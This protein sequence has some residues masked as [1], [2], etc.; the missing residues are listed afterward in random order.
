MSSRNKR[1]QAAEDM[2]PGMPDI[3]GKRPPKATENSWASRTLDEAIERSYELLDQAIVRFSTGDATSSRKKWINNPD[4]F[5]K[6]GAPRKIQISTPINYGPSELAGIFGLYSGG[7]DSVNTMHL[8]R[9][10]MKDRPLFRHF[11][12]GIVHVNTG[13]AIAETTQHVREAV[14][15]W[16]MKLHELHPKAQYLDLVLG[17]VRATVG[18]NIGRSVWLGFPGPGKLPHNVFYRRLKD[19]PLQRLRASLVGQEGIRRKVMY[20]GGMRWDESDKR[21]RTAEEIDVD[22]GIVWVSPVVHWTNAHMREYRTRY[23]CEKA[24]KHQPHRLCGDEA[25][26]A[27]PVTDNLH[28]SGDCAC[29]AYAKKDEKEERRFFYPQN[30]E[31]IDLWEKTVRDAGIAANVWGQAPPKGFAQ[32]GVDQPTS[33]IERLCSNCKPPIPGQDDLIDQWRDTGLITPEQH[34]A[35]TRS[36]A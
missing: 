12:C 30:A 32:A 23:R 17:N 5:R 28:M 11:F 1:A 13:T 24:H 8:L 22:G 36:A 31:L 14:P 19:E 20:I 21:F 7:R 25:L 9:K 3:L 2:F 27:N 16:G 18:P 34:A 33:V 4:Y 10:Y 15:A 26:P 29:G 35:F 6:R